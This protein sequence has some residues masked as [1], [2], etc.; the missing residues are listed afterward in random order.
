MKPDI[1]TKAVLTVIAVALSVIAIR[2]LINPGTTASAQAASF[3][4]LQYS[5]WDDQAMFFD[6]RTGEIWQ[7]HGP[8]AGGRLQAKM[9]LSKLGQPLTVEVKNQ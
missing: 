8:N 1:Y 5:N 3:A 4:G 9:R 2:P 6:P 7:Y